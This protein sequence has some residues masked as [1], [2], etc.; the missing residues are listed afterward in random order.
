VLG[1]TRPLAEYLANCLRKEVVI[2]LQLYHPLPSSLFTLPS[3]TP[4]VNMAERKVTSKYFPPD[5]DPAAIEG[6]V[7]KAKKDGLKSIPV[8]LMAPFSMKC[9]NCGEYIYKGRKFNARKETLDEKY[10]NTPIFRFYIRCTDC[11]HE[12]T[13]RT[14]PKSKPSSFS[15]FSF[16]LTSF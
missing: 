3:P 14:D 10:L 6:R 9:T 2:C 15:S 12:I 8:R 5:F 7:K 16:C 4:F 13:F 1:G 11:K